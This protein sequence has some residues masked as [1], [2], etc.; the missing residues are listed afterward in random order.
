M[1]FSLSA[2]LL[3]LL[4]VGCSEDDPAGPNDDTNPPQGAAVQATPA[5]TFSPGQ[6]G[7]A[8]G[9]A[10]TWE[11]QSVAHNV[12]FD[13]TAGRPGDIPGF[14]SGSSISRTFGTA[15]TFDYECRIHPG[16]RG[17]VVVSE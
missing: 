16:M 3:A 6:I 2:V 15:G 11:F 10:V 5:I 14:N 8:A 13:A 12:F 7:I 17:T 4:V 9:E 1:R